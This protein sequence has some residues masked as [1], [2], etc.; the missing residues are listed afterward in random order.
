MAAISEELIFDDAAK[1]DMDDSVSSGDNDMKRPLDD[2]EDETMETGD[3]KRIACTEV[4]VVYKLLCANSRISRVIGKGG[5]VINA[6][7]AETGAKI[8]V[9]DRIPGCDERLIV[10]SAEDTPATETCPSQVALCAV[11]E[12]V[13]GNGEDE[14]DSPDSSANEQEETIRLLAHTTQVG[15]VIGKGGEA[16]N[17]LRSRTGAAIR[18]L[19][20]HD[21]PLCASRTDEVCQISGSPDQ[22]RLAVGEISTRL[23]DNPIK[24]KSPRIRSSARSD[25][26]RAS[27]QIP[28]FRGDSGIGAEYR[29]LAPVSKAGFVIG[30]SGEHVRRIRQETGAIVHLEPVEDGC[31]W[32]VVVVRS[33]EGSTAI[34]CGAQEALLR[35]VHRCCKQDEAGR[36][37]VRLLVSSGQVGAVLGKG[38]AVISAMRADSGA[39]IRVVTGADDT[40]DILSCAQPGDAMVVVEGRP[41][42]VDAALTA[43]MLCLGGPTSTFPAPRA[44]GPGRRSVHLIPSFTNPPMEPAGVRQVYPGEGNKVV[45]H[46]AA[47]QVGAVIGKGGANITQIRSISGAGVRL[48]EGEGGAEREL[49]I[50]GSEAQCHSANNLVQAFLWRGAS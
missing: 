38:G 34:Y 45:M 10:I 22:V 29:F 12:A 3:E 43:V 26:E 21:L 24:E 36:L 19:P 7:R 28:A 16:I 8:T 25:V 14:D 40:D 44:S 31:D 23:R 35:C 6:L 15:G 49:E 2:D 11:I 33:T 4:E 30:R 48:V 27:K 32:R 9:K 13:L 18:V 42:A 41:P 37:T 47:D 5:E 39:S 46:I 50:T 20:N 1:S 17:E